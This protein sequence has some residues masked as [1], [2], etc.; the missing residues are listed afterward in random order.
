MGV[1]R[2]W[3][4][5]NARCSTQFESWDANPECPTCRC[6]RVQW[7][8]GG[9]HVAGTAKAADAE[10]RA[11]A[12]VFKM[13]DMHSAERDYAAKRVS[14]PTSAGS[15]PM[16]FGNGFAANVN[17]AAGAQCV[18]TANRINYKVKAGQGQKLAPSK[19]FANPRTNTVFEG[20][21][22]GK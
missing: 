22:T 17:P 13:T 2:H 6:V 3:Q 15:A 4:C 12:D 11:L 9:G 7:I 21:S 1:I 16:Q 14:T 19:V 8:P 20:R 5:M 18:P 10:L